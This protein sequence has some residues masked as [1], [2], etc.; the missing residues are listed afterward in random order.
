MISMVPFKVPSEASNGTNGISMEAFN[1]SKCMEP[2]GGIPTV[3][4]F[5]NC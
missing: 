5:H 3:G 4:L 2:I 1:G